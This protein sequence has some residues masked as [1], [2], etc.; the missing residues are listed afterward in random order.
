MEPGVWTVE[1][2]HEEP[3]VI[4]L[5]DPVSRVTR[6]VRVGVLVLLL[7]LFLIPGALDLRSNNESVPPSTEAQDPAREQICQP[8]FELPSMLDPLSDFAVPSFMRLCDWFA[9][10]NQAPANRESQ[11]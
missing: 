8:A 11:P 10:P 5:D 7:G 3:I 2:Q 9:V 6:F 4:H 1:N